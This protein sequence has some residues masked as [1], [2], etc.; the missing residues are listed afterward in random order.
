MTLSP[1]DFGRMEY[2]LGKATV[3]GSLLPP[4]ENELRN[5][6]GQE[7]PQAKGKTLSDLITLGLILVGIYLLAKAFEK[8]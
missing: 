6:I 8:E 5:F 2:L 7:N 4:E 3:E 1:D